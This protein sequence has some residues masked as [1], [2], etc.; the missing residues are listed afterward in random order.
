MSAGIAGYSAGMQNSETQPVSPLDPEVCRRARLARD[1]RFDGEFF[2]AVA[3]TGIYCR[4]VCPAR[5]PAEKNVHYYRSAAEAAA[6][7]YRPCLRCRP[8]SAP[9][10]PAWR[11]SATTVGRALNLID[12]GALASGN[13]GELA[14]RL[15]VGERHLR[16][17]FQQQLGASPQAVA[18]NQRLLFAR[19]LLS[20]TDLPITQVAFAA[21]F[22]SVRRFNS[23]VQEKLRTTPRALRAKRKGSTAEAGVIELQLQYREPYD[24]AGVLDFFRRHALAGV[25]QVGENHYR[26]NISIGGAT[27]WFQLSPIAGRNR[28]RLQLHLSD[29]GQLLPAVTRIRRMFDL[30]ANP[31]VIAAALATSPPLRPLLE[32]FPGVRSPVQWSA[33]EATVRAVVGQQVSIAAARGVLA[34]LSLAARGNDEGAF[35]S[36]AALAALDDKHF[37]MPGR[38]RQTLQAICAA[39]T[40]GEMSL[41]ELADC[42]GIGPWT[43][44]LVAMRGHG[45]PDS[46][47]P[48]DLGL[49]KAWDSLAGADSDLQAQTLH[50]RPWRAYAANLLWRSLP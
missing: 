34:K 40:S 10:S 33:L 23:A 6:Q 18:H 26:R 41:D 16:K 29:A 17:L 7:G 20:E 8:E 44:A 4:P 45:D 24:W 42:K 22:N 50:W 43:V 31:E 5:T 39:H 2:L 28:M 25:E 32:R 12:A 48:K 37:A 1:P 21:G 11:G 14:A 38:R 3:T 35:P 13:L 36:A 30:D 19:K 15:G 46:F 27:G 47:P 49:V 9:N